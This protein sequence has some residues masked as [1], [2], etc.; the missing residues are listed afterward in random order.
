MNAMTVLSTDKDDE[1]ITKAAELVPLLRER[2]REV[3]EGRRLTDENIADLTELGLY[4]AP[5][6]AH[7]GGLETPLPVICRALAE[8]GRGCTST[9]WVASTGVVSSW[10]VGHF[11][12]SVQEKV[13]ADPD[14]RVCGSFTPAAKLTPVDD[15]YRLSGT[16]P[17]NTGCLHAQWDVVVAMLDEDGATSM[18]LCALP[19]TDL[20]IVDDW[21][22]YGMRGTGSCT[23][24]ADDIFVA[25]DHVIDLVELMRGHWVEG[26]RN[27]SNP[28]YR[29]PAW[30]MFIVTSGAVIPG[31]TR[32]ALEVFEKRIVGRAITYTDY[33]DQ[34]QTA[35]AQIELAK[36]AV[37]IEAAELIVHN[38]VDRVWTMGLDS[39]DPDI[40]QRQQIS[41]A[42]GYAAEISREAVEI[43]TRSSGA[44]SIRMDSIS[45]QYF[46]DMEALTMHGGLN[47]TNLYESYGRTRLGLT[48]TLK[49][50]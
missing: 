50:S 38:L 11:P 28:L 46:R 27:Y 41:A 44:S 31:V 7:Y 17:F 9:G 22:T 34:S 16:W 15:G 49:F 12:D 35:P 29:V 19:M 30:P 2:T 3:D 10:M 26:R 42:E 24:R 13:F 8:I 20:S 18:K 40:F 45:Q 43:V 6:P 32:G 25:E 47:L 21:H 23:T 36:A 14:V 1:M 37:R 33:T 39:I 5:L 48:P 4:R